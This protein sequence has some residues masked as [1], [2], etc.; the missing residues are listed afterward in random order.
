VSRSVRSGNGSRDARTGP[1]ASAVPQG[2]SATP[3][4]ATD[5]R[6]EPAEQARTQTQPTPEP[7]ERHALVTGASRGIGAAIARRLAGDGFRLSLLGRDRDALHAVEATLAPGLHTV[8]VADVT[9][10]AA[11][12]AAVTEARTLLGPVAV[13]VNN[14]GAA[15]SAP[16]ARTSRAL[17][18]RMLAVN[19]TSAYLCSQAVLADLRRAA[20]ERAS[21]AARGARIVNIASTAGQKG[22]P[23]VAAYVAA[24]HGLVGLTR[25]LALELATDGVTVNAVCPGFTDTALLRASVQRIVERTGR[26]ESDAVQALTV[27]NPQGRLIDPDEVAAAVAWLVSD[28]A[29]SITGQC[30]SVS[31]G[32]VMS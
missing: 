23:Y 7:T 4:A 24:K 9:D 6:L 30:L 10:E 15:E 28:A 32:E 19:L 14:A 20:S 27:H 1:H 21:H 26:S 16:L 18:D 3:A 29:A 22:Y 13:L 12:H 2:A 11:V 25:A 31:G 5:A 17:W 8:V